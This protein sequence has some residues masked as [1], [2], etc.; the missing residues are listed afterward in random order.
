MPI[1]LG[2]NN[3]YRTQRHTIPAESVY[4]VDFEGCNPNYYRL[5]NTGNITLFCATKSLPT[6]DNYNFKANPISVANFCE[7][8]V[9]DKLYILNNTKEDVKVILTTWEGEFNPTFMAVSEISLN[10]EGTIKTDGIINGFT[11]P[12]PSGDNTIGKVGLDEKA[13]NPIESILMELGEVW[14]TDK[15]TSTIRTAIQDTCDKVKKIQQTIDNNNDVSKFGTV[16]QLLHQIKSQSICTKFEVEENT[17][18]ENLYTFSY[19]EL[20][21]N[22]GENDINLVIAGNRFVLKPNEVINKM[23]LEGIQTVKIPKNSSYRIIGG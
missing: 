11:V 18:A 16:L 15:G 7:P 8:V 17:E 1:Y 2:S 9:R 19:I 12:L 6:T 4:T 20:L 14:N 21:S 3:G 13:L 10:N 22:D 23:L 5:M